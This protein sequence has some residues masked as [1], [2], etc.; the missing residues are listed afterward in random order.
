MPSSA[1]R[2][3]MSQG[4]AASIRAHNSPMAPLHHWSRCAAASLLFAA[5]ALA[6][7]AGFPDYNGIVAEM[8]T[9]ANTHPSICQLVNLSAVYGITT[10]NGN[11]TFAL[12]ISD[13]VGTD[14]DEP[15]FLMVSAHH[16]NEYG[17][18]IVALDAI[19]RLTSGYGSD[20]TIT[21]LV[22]EYEIW[23][24]PVWNP[25]GYPNSRQNSRPGGSVD[26]NRN[27][28]FLWDSPCNT[29]V[30]GPS[31]GSEPETQLMM[32]FSEDRR[33]TKVL[34]YHSSGQETLYGY[35]SSCGQHVFGAYLQ[36]EAAALAQASGYGGATREPSSNGEHYQWQIGRFSNL[37]F[38]TEISTTQSPSRASADAEAALLWPGTLHFLQLPVPVRGHVTDA[39]TGLPVEAS[40]T[41]VENPF[42]EGELNRAEPR[43]GRYHA[44]VPNGSH[45]LRFEAP[46][47]ATIE[48]PVSVGAA[49]VT[50]DVTM[51]PPSISFAFPN[52][53]PTVV[54]PAGGTVVR[55][56]V[57]AGGNVP[58][59]GTGMLHVDSVNGSAVLPMA[60]VAANSYDA[61]FPA[62]ACSGDV[63]FSF[64]AED[65]GGT[66]RFAPV[67]GAYTASLAKVTTVLSTDD[68]EAAGGWAGGQ[69]GDTA[70]TGIWDRAD[71]QGTA[72][73]PEDDH[74]PGGG[75]NCW[76]TDS[77]AGTGVGSWDVDGGFTTLLSPA[78]DLSAEPDAVIS[79]WRW[80]SNSAGG[81]PNS[82][83][84]RVDV[85]DDDGQSWT[86]AETVGPL[87]PETSGGWIQ[88][89]FAVADFVSTT[90]VVRVRIVAEDAGGGS[91]V[92]AGVDDFE[93]IRLSC[94]GSVT[95]AGAGCLD[96]TS[97]ELA[98]TYAGSVHV[99]GTIEFGLDAGAALPW[100]LLAGSNGLAPGVTIP[101]TGV[102]G[103][104]LD[105]LVEF[106]VGPLPAGSSLAIPLP[107]N[108]S[109]AG[110]QLVWQGAM[111]DAGVAAPIKAVTS[112]TL[113]TMFGS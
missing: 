108:P 95:R 27:Y 59:A 58:V 14:E 64:S 75:V 17:T 12:R 45:T 3:L 79:Y 94:D 9:A 72:A 39:V 24:A 8:T 37:A 67:A 15:K 76:V 83:V 69:P 57:L 93:V 109:L 7:P 71:P 99:G 103:C 60:S 47:Y 97:Q 16:G 86:N 26:L 46:G 112:D 34:D 105:V 91:I 107:P 70:T 43:F 88:H 56:D 73:Q 68:F 85:S 21:A 81:N 23:I 22:D 31:A 18:P 90:A 13:N 30:R 89:Q 92:E 52:G 25:D 11:S 54:E 87:G 101:G 6:Q 65:G 28:P 10:H 61:V 33:F 50:L 5:P 53:I 96:S 82:D 74:T 55:V 29:G 49:G 77:R 4:D 66:R 110:L 32:A 19:A 84:L 1:S 78:L 80:Y 2:T 51:A 48:V 38:L 106:T 41:Y 62:F 40:I 44:F 104:T 42:T 113:T 102:P 98:L 36:A 63:R 100:V 35:R 20:P 111:A